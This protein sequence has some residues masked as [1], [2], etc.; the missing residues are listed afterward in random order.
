MNV[1]TTAKNRMLTKK[2]PIKFLA[3]KTFIFFTCITKQTIFK[4]G[5]ESSNVSL[6]SGQTRFDNLPD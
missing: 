1:L 5:S 2:Q 6:S 4:T 3:V